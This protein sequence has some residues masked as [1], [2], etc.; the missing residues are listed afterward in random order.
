VKTNHTRPTP[1]ADST[2]ALGKLLSRSRRGGRR[3]GWASPAVGLLAAAVATAAFVACTSDVRKEAAPGTPPSQVDAADAKVLRDLSA[4]TSEAAVGFDPEPGNTGLHMLGDIPAIGRSTN[5]IGAGQYSLAEPGAD[6]SAAYTVVPND[7]DGFAAIAPGSADGALKDSFTADAPSNPPP[8]AK[9]TGDRGAAAIDPAA[10]VPPGRPAGPGGAGTEAKAGRPRAGTEFGGRVEGRGRAYVQ[11]PALE[12]MRPAMHE[13][14][15][16]IQRYCPPGAT[17]GPDGRI[18]RPPAHGGGN[19]DDFPGCGALTTTLPGATTTVPVP[20]KH[21]AVVADVAGNIAGVKVTQSY[22]NPFA[23]KI[24]AV[25]VF[26]LPDNAAVSD[27]VMTIG[28]RTIRGVVR[29]RSEAE[30]VYEAARAQGYTASLMTQERPNIFTQKVANIE[31]GK[32]IDV[33]VTYYNT[34]AYVDGAFEFVFPM[35]VGPR[36]NPPAFYDGVGA[37]ARGTPPG[38]TGQATEVQYLRP[39]ERSGHD[40]SVRVNIDAGVAIESVTSL[41]H[42]VETTRDPANPSRASVTLSAKDTIPNKDLVLR[43]AVAANKLKTGMVT[44]V[45]KDGTGYFSLLIVPPAQTASLQR[46]PVE[47]VFVLDCSGSMSGRPIQQA[48]AA[49]ERGLRRLNPGDTFQVINF[50]NAASQLGPKPLPA[51]PEN[52]QKGLTY[53]RSLFAEG[54]TMMV[55]GLR[56]ALDFPHDKERLR[57]VCFLTDGY[58]GNETEVLS[59]MGARLRESRIFSFGVGSST[60]RYLLE[61]M[62]RNGR[63]CVAHVAQGDNPVA[64]MDAFFDRVAHPALTGVKVELALGDLESA[65][66]FPREIPDVYVGRPVVVNGRFKPAA[67]AVGPSM[68]GVVVRGSRAGQA[69]AETIPFDTGR[70]HA[71]LPAIWARGKIADLADF[72]TSETLARIPEEVKAVA[73]A[74]G[75]ISPFTAFIAV[76]SL[77]PTKGDFGTTVVVPVPMPEGVRYETTVTER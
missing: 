55:P 7:R 32:A 26:P 54:G 68:P 19:A 46:A 9:P 66:V 52:I 35:V 16:V 20:L 47:L 21:T 44:R 1:C 45:E 33:T 53:A 75:L 36:F 27:F 50:A 10:P 11:L 64:V 42:V 34:L 72:A 58:I 56:A 63:G 43:Y 69:V 39:T 73:L 59:E 60:N 12:A 37:V 4:V 70:T 24:E 18:V 28:D 61:A 25:Y 77:A 5:L 65:E 6:L 15:W 67:N 22:T 76:D 23:S 48:V 17:R 40:V 62:A 14:V 49:L 29:D 41:S 13:E 51:T 3:R 71:A 2:T 8:N 31:P 74:Y 38:T 57:Y 30:K